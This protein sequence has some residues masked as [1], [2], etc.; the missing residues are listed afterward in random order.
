MGANRKNATARLIAGA[1]MIS[2]SPVFVRLMEVPPTMS[3]FYRTLIGGLI[4]LVLVLAQRR[5]L[6]PGRRAFFILALAGALF[7]G[8][9]W[10]WHR[11][12][13]YVGPGL[14]TLLGNFQVFVLAL[15]GILFFGERMSWRL[16]VALPTAV[17]GLALIVGVDWSIVAPEYRW[18]VVFGLLTALFYA[19]YILSLRRAR[20]LE[21]EGSPARDLAL[22]SLMATVLLGLIS[23]AEGTSLV[24]PTFYDA[25]LLVGYA[26]VAQVIGWVLIS[27]S[28]PYVPPSRVGLILLLQPFL[29]FVWDVL[30]FARPTTG[31]ELIGAGLVLVAIFLGSRR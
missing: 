13:D 21:P 7:A 16:A 25:G 11:S 8:D 23:G 19:A 6:V 9:L 1:V 24:I 26:V 2:V 31:R 29:A 22:A 18:G 4:L 10:V 17:A 27:G 28:L 12:I 3:A 14:A 20:A 5:K 30:F 15:A